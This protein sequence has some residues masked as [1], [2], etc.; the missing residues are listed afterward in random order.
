MFGTA[1]LLT[2]NDLQILDG[3]MTFCP[4]IWFKGMIVIIP[5]YLASL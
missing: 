2:V 4:A 3:S 5:V 1:Y